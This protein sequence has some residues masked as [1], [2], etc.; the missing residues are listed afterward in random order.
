MTLS[1]E[2]VNILKCKST[3]WS[4]TR[5]YCVN[6]FC[7]TRR[8]LSP[9]NSCFPS[10]DWVQS[11]RLPD[12][13]SNTASPTE[14]RLLFR[15]ASPPFS[16]RFR[17]RC[18]CEGVFP[19]VEALP[20]AHAPEPSAPPEGVPPAAQAPPTDERRDTSSRYWEK[21]WSMCQVFLIV[22]W[23]TSRVDEI[24][25][26]VMYESFSLG[27]REEIRNSRYRFF[28]YFN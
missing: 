25:G 15:L 13:L 2:G 20:A 11:S 27:S 12:R 14:D 23:I 7:K 5:I 18:S 19:A 22:L 3:Q 8:Q 10:G 24:N 16:F 26:I 6:K 1:R 17:S 28:I 9:S 21:V 4:F